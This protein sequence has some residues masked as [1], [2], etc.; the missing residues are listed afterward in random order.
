M[1]GLTRF[2]SQKATGRPVNGIRA[3]VV[4]FDDLTETE[5]AVPWFIDESGT[6]PGSNQTV[7]QEFQVNIFLPT[8]G[9]YTLRYTSVN[10]TSFHHVE[11]NVVVGPIGDELPP[12]PDYWPHF[13]LRS[14]EDNG[15]MLLFLLKN[16]EIDT[17][18]H[19][20][21]LMI[22]GDTVEEFSLFDSV[23]YPISGLSTGDIIEV[24]FS[25]EPFSKLG[26]AITLLSGTRM[27]LLSY[28]N[29]IIRSLELSCVT[30][31][32]D[33]LPFG[34]E[35][36]SFEGN[37]WFNDASVTLWDT[38]R[39]CSMARMFS[40]CV[41][42]N[43]PIG[44]WD[45]R[46]VFDFDSMFEGA[47][48]FS[49]DLSSWEVYVMSEPIGFSESSGLTPEQTPKWGDYSPAF[50]KY[51]PDTSAYWINDRNLDIPFGFSYVRFSD[52]YDNGPE[53]NGV[54]HISVSDS[55]GNIGWERTVNF[56]DHVH[57]SDILIPWVGFGT[58][59]IRKVDYPYT[60]PV[61]VT[62]GAYVACQLQ[63]GEQSNVYPLFEWCQRLTTVDRLLPRYMD[64]IRRMFMD[65]RAFNQN[66]VT[67][68]VSNI[69]T[70]AYAFMRAYRFNGDLSSWNTSQMTD[71]Q[72]MFQDASA[73]NS[74]IGA[75]DVRNVTNFSNFLYGALSFNQNLTCWDVEHVPVL[76]SGFAVVSQ[77]QAEFY[78]LWGQSITDGAGRTGVSC[79]DGP[80]PEPEPAGG[81][82][83]F[84]TYD[85]GNRFSMYDAGTKT[86][87]PGTPVIPASFGGTRESASVVAYDPLRRRL[88]FARRE[89]S[90][91][92]I[93]FYDIDSWEMVSSVVLPGEVHDLRYN[94]EYTLLVVTH[95]NGNL[96]TL[97]DVST[98]EIVTGLPSLPG[99][100]WH[101]SK[102]ADF[103]MTR[104]YGLAI[105]YRGDWGTGTG[106]AFIS[107][108][109]GAP[110]YGSM[111]Q[112][113]PVPSQPEATVD[114]VRYIAG[115]T[116][117]AVLYQNPSS[118]YALHIVDTET[119]LA[120]RKVNPPDMWLTTD[121]MEITSDGKFCIILA[122]RSNGHSLY[123]YNILDDVWLPL[124]SDN[125]TGGYGTGSN[126]VLSNDES[127]I[128]FAS[129]LVISTLTWEI[130]HH[131]RLDTLL[132]DNSVWERAIAVMTVR[133]QR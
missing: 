32:P 61:P 52:H 40:G 37:I 116:L 63:F 41:A 78:P 66:L 19:A 57:Y 103:D 28:G 71:F 51:E 90:V 100:A 130:I 76:P 131:P 22:N 13:T 115:T 55:R 73:F 36:I 75:W 45:V 38:S 120:V 85:G 114:S 110:N 98:L 12:N 82:I 129:G 50:Y 74:D 4:T 64:S 99:F 108:N 86:L 14:E 39:L 84:V 8:P 1:Y 27:E 15:N 47:T 42:F 95:L 122:S 54:Y 67:W 18:T 35:R 133:N 93:D 11:E 113:T 123:V 70:A 58:L 88:A 106:A 83:H 94:D 34:L 43:Q 97:Y 5:I 25:D 96:Y 117:A 26:S 31:V 119:R 105:A 46:N 77:L 125:W 69:K 23:A 16:P 33:F 53:P 48:M 128:A 68:D 7:F 65:A 21:R 91:H 6:T 3:E 72:S 81:D 132:G 109:D 9:T 80:D 79:A 87:V 126:F 24:E 60:T 30:A 112:Y 44:H 107:V 92:R 20:V 56:A 101:G 121:Q 102:T 89:S 59:L 17:Q 118:P 2:F 29:S 49:R 104:D 111:W 10:D 127:Y 124:L 62:I